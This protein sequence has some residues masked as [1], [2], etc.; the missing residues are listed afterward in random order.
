MSFKIYFFQTPPPAPPAQRRAAVETLNLI[1]IQLLSSNLVAFMLFI[2]N[3]LL[4][5]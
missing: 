3:V 1:V 5:F 4:T 2:E